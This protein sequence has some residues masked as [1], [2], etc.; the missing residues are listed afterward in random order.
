MNQDNSSPQNNIFHTAPQPTIP[1]KWTLCIL[2]L[3]ETSILFHLGVRIHDPTIFLFTS[4]FQNYK[5]YEID[6]LWGE[7]LPNLLPP[8]FKLIAP[9]YDIPFLHLAIGIF[10][11]IL[12]TAIYFLIAWKITGN[13]FASTMATTLMFGLGYLRLGEYDIFNLRF[14]TGLAGNELRVSAFISFRQIGMV[15]S[16]TA[17]YF[18]LRSRFTL[19]SF[20]LA[21]GVLFHSANTINFFLCFTVA[22]ALCCLIKKEKK[23]YIKALLS[24][25]VLFS[26]CIIP[27]LIQI[28]GVF[29]YVDPIKFSNFWDVVAANEADDATLLYY[30][31]FRKATIFSWLGM[32]LV[33]LFLHFSNTSQKPV[34]RASIRT[35]IAGTHDVLSPLF[36]AILIV[37]SFAIIWE[38]TLIPILPDFLND[39]IASLNLRR[40]TTLSSLI[41]IAIIGMFLSRIIVFLIQTAYS[42]IKGILPTVPSKK[43]SSKSADI[44]F[45]LLLSIFVLINTFILDGKNAKLLNEIKSN[46]INNYIVFEHK[47]YKYFR[48]ISDYL[49]TGPA[50][51]SPEGATIP[52][53]S[54]WEICSWIRKNTE[55]SSA[56][57]QPTYLHEFREC[58]MRQGFLSVQ[59]DGILA[60]FNRKYATLYLERF[61]TI[62]KE[63]TYSQ[64]PGLENNRKSA[65]E[66][67]RQK[68]LSIDK[69]DLEKLKLLYPGYSYFLTESSHK[70]PYQIAHQNDYFTLYKISK[71]PPNK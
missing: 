3:L 58:A 42:E 25:T 4:L 6:P 2:I 20:F 43:F 57:I 29:D 49:K 55:S 56:F 27:Y 70:L 50:Y 38:S 14:P 1:I 46:S 39:T 37:T 61:T 45:S 16:L 44:S 33:A 53:N 9:A 64:L 23:T 19:C 59:M 31:N 26:I 7:L 17:L 63:T 62:H 68:Y 47:D 71:E 34:N 48:S 10:T 35:S 60:A 8:F 28:Q 40:T 5:E 18:F 24:S 67:L 22:L 41:S 11:K 15:F 65:Y 30:F 66:A 36:F 32:T 52:F 69:F 13:L 51:T 12:L 21:T 54:F